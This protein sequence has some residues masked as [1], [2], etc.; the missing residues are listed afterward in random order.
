MCLINLAK[1]CKENLQ[2]VWAKHAWNLGCDLTWPL[3]SLNLLLWGTRVWGQPGCFHPTYT[4]IL[5][6][7]LRGCPVSASCSSVMTQPNS[8]GRKLSWMDHWF[9]LKWQIPCCDFVSRQEIAGSGGGG[10]IRK[11]A[12]DVFTIVAA[13][14]TCHLHVC[15]PVLLLMAPAQLPI[16]PEKTWSARGEAQGSAMKEIAEILSH[17]I[18][19]SMSGSAPQGFLRSG[20]WLA[21]LCLGFHICKLGIIILTCHNCQEEW[22]QWHM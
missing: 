19:G 10:R 7:C 13:A 2:A 9:D 6:A 17:I 16:F 4:A 21:F 12:G 20:K 8:R 22:I 1:R 15:T 11:R 18:L 3:A 14:P 5:F